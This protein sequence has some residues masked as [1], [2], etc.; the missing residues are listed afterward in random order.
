V[1][2]KYTID[3]DDQE[4]V[5][6]T[7]LTNE[8]W[9]ILKPVML[10]RLSRR[11]A[12][13]TISLRAILN[14]CFYITKNGCIWDDLPKEYPDHNIVWYH[15]NKWCRD[16][17]WELINRT[18]YEQVRVKQGREATPS[19]GV[20]DGQSAKTTEIGGNGAMNVFKKLTVASDMPF[21]TL[22]AT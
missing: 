12:P 4:P 15:Y 14:G 3:D 11:G 19:A 21:Q 22:K 1:A 17:T 18:L 6:S 9:S 10:S 5:Y 16:G 13:M 7:D 8:A 2:T 20:A